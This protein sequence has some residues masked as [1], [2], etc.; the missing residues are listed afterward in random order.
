MSLNTSYDCDEWII[1]VDM[2]GESIRL[3]SQIIP[4]EKKHPSFSGIEKVFNGTQKLNRLFLILQQ[5]MSISLRVYMK[6]GFKFH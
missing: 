2:H 6:L 3:C 4:M 1:Q 5:N